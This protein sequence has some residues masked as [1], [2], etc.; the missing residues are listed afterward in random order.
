M[1]GEGE[2]GCQRLPELICRLA[3]LRGRSVNSA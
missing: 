3:E 1:T 2:A